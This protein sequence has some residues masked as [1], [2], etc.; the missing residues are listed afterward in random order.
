M[1]SKF[2]DVLC[3]T[4]NETVERVTVFVTVDM[5]L[6]S[7]TVIVVDI[8]GKCCCLSCDSKT[9]VSTSISSRAEHGDT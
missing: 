2:V 5:M 9:R 3:V 1:I 7:G 4:V 6:K 8:A